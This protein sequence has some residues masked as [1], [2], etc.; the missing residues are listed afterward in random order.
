VILFSRNISSRSQLRSLTR[1]LQK[2]VPDG[3]PPLLVTIDQ[4]GGLVKRL[5][6]PP[7]HSA[8][9]I[10]RRNSTKLARD[11]G[12]ATADN[13]LDVGVNV[14]LAP[15]V[16]VGRPGSIMR[17]QER[18]YSGDPD[19]VARL[20]GA[21]AKGLR[22]GHVGATAKHFPGLGAAT[23]NEDTHSNRIGLS[24]SEL[25]ATDELPFRKLAADGLPL[26]MVS[27]A[28]YPAFD[29]R[30]ALFS[31]RIANKEL[32]DEAGFEGVSITDD[33]NTPVAE[34]HGSAGRR[35][36]LAAHAGN[37][38]LLYAQSYIDGTRAARELVDAVR[39]DRLSR[40]GMKAAADRVRA[41]RQSFAG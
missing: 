19:K 11:E 37:D 29:D 33:L 26:V 30:P 3:D 14:N 12:R 31:P 15:V 40:S 25:R 6:G 22:N 10:G 1:S 36:V 18:S 7:D 13:L 23:E 21:F 38:L 17:R 2:A 20:A 39:A 34:R 32:R 35:A 4:E 28:V 24:K 5:S 9:E 41:L 8:A 27:T 16:D